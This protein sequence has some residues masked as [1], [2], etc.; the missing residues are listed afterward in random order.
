MISG[1]YHFSTG[2]LGKNTFSKSLI[3]L[4]E[5]NLFQL[6]FKPAPKSAIGDYCEISYPI[7]F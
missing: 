2:I 4:I 7:G 6:V 1:F 5:D 3:F